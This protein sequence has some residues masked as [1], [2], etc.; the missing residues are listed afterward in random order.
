[1]RRDVVMGEPE[2]RAG[3]VAE[4]LLGEQRH[5]AVRVRTP[6]AP[7]VARTRTRCAAR[8]SRSVPSAATRCEVGVA[9]GLSSSRCARPSSSEDEVEAA[10]PGQ[11]E[12]ADDGLDGVAHVRV[13][14]DPQHRRR[15]RRPVT[16]DH[17]GL[18]GAQRRRPGSRRPRRSPAGRRRRT[19]SRGWDGF[20]ANR[21]RSGPRV[22]LHDEPFQRRGRAA[23]G[24]ASRARPCRPSASVRRIATPRPPQLPSVLSTAGPG[25][26]FEPRGDVAGRAHDRGRRAE[27]PGA[28]GDRQ[29]GGAGVD[30][31]DLVRRPERALEALAHAG[32]RLRCAGRSGHGAARARGACGRRRGRRRRRPRPRSRPAGSGSGR[33]GRAG[34]CAGRPRPHATALPRGA[35]P[36]TVQPTSW[37]STASLA[38]PGQRN[39]VATSTLSRGARRC[40]RP[41]HGPRQPGR[42]R[43]GLGQVEVVAPDPSHLQLRAA[44]AATARPGRTRSPTPW[45]RTA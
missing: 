5:Q 4:Q 9:R 31:G 19:G 36:S 43:G 38:A 29:H 25:V 18:H 17:L 12:V 41:A 14:D 13:V 24:G 2:V 42:A 27:H 21:A 7:V 28:A 45:P 23:G 1:M 40:E 22:A 15:T 11:L 20:S 37:R 39:V 6:S 8:V 30:A 34:S 16:L 32:S 44:T 26:A 33:R 35:T 10:Q 3:G